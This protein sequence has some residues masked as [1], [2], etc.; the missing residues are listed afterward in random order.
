MLALGR[1]PGSNSTKY[2]LN[3]L[4]FQKA[5]QFLAVQIVGIF[6]ALVVPYL[7][8]IN[9][10]WFGYDFTPLVILTVNTAADLLRRWLSGPP[11][12]PVPAPPV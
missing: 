11:G 8:H 12:L 3:S 10:K 6:L 2:H 4:D 1:L 7:T 5:W 9:Y